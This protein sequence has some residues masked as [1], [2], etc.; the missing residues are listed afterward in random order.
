MADSPFSD[1][2]PSFQTVYELGK[3]TMGLF[4]T[5]QNREIASENESFYD[6]QAQINANIGAFNETVARR[7]GAVMVRNIVR[8][9]KDV[10]GEQLAAFQSRG[11]EMAGTP[12]MVIDDTIS[13]G[14]STAYEAA[15][16]S[17]VSAINARYNALNA[18]QGAHI[19][20]SEA[21]VQRQSANM[22][23]IDQIFGAGKFINS[24]SNSTN[25]ENG[26]FLESALNQ[27]TPGK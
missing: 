6:M 20:A 3:V 19:K 10:V 1:F 18:T 22:S 23:L 13:K 27:R 25:Q 5:L 14:L 8:Q 2:L 15:Y 21:A 16:R 11:I 12:Q 17:E 9:T 4:G 26:N 7:A 24:L